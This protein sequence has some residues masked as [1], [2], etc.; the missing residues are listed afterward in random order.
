[1]HL[2]KEGE[3]HWAVYNPSLSLSLSLSLS[4]PLSLLIVEAMEGKTQVYNSLAELNSLSLYLAYLQR[5]PEADSK[6]R[7]AEPSKMQERET[8]DGSR[9]VSQTNECPDTCKELD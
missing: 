7:C 4:P 9:R 8:F 6:L 3:K 2:R 5:P 1:M